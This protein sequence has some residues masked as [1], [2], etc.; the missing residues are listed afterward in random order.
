MVT[1]ENAAVRSVSTA[2]VHRRQIRHRAAAFRFALSVPDP[3]SSHITHSIPGVAASS[4]TAETPAR[5][6]TRTSAAA[7]LSLAQS[8][9]RLKT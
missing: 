1:A 4:A 2:A 3:I 9:P 5:R 6:Q 8:D 7:A